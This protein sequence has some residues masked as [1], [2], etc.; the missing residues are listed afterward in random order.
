MPLA[1][2]R[3]AGSRV[4][5]SLASALAPAV[6][7]AVCF[8]L[9]AVLS[10]LSAR[11]FLLDHPNE[12]SLHSRPVPRIGGLGLV[13]GALVAMAVVGADVR[14]AVGAALLAA[15]SLVDDWRSLPAG[16]RLVAHLAVAG[17]FVVAIGVTSIALV[18]LLAV[19]VAWLA[20]LY[21]FM[22][23]SDGLAGTMAVIGFGAYA[24]AASQA[25]DVELATASLAIVGAAAGFLCFNVPPARLFLGDAG[26]VPLGFLAG[27]LG[28]LGWQRGVWPL[29]FAPFVFAP[30]TVDA[31]LTLARRALRREPV[32]QAHREH[33]YQRLIRMGWSHRRTLIA[34]ALLMVFCAGAAMTAR[35]S[36]VFTQVAAMW[37]VGVLMVG[38]MLAVDSAWKRHAARVAPVARAASGGRP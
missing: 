10:R 33:W 36:P 31:T 9:L 37:V 15:I 7:F 23:G 29:W 25:G 11:R 20:N 27:A 22:D 35:V 12:R 30:F 34:E 21:N 13:P 4:S 1:V 28:V 5:S 6:A 19:A 16:A 3:G 24:I 14:L 38:L 26:S 2:D 8:V 17:G 32:W 18:V